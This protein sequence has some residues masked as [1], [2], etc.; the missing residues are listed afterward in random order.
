[1][2]SPSGRQEDIDSFYSYGN[3]KVASV[4]E[5]AGSSI[6]GVPEKSDYTVAEMIMQ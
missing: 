4:L 5:M 6:E 2:C 1:L 3:M